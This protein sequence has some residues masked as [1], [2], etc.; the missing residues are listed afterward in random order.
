MTESTDHPLFTLV[1][2]SPYRRIVD[3]GGGSGATLELIINAYP[4]MRGILFDL[5]EVIETLQI[6]MEAMNGRL[7]PVGGDFFAQVPS[8]GDLYLLERV[9]SDWDGDWAQGILQSAHKAMP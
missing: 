8:G 9:L 4:Q 6:N 3:I 7:V 5:P 1:D 2:L